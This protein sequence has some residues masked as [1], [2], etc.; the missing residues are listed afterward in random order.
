MRDSVSR[1][2]R[3]RPVGADSQ[4][5]VGGAVEKIVGRRRISQGPV[6]QLLNYLAIHLLLEA[7]YC[8]RRRFLI[9]KVVAI[10]ISEE[11]ARDSDS[12]NN[13]TCRCRFSA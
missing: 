2:I 13:G 12:R 6:R 8:A 5:E 1:T 4:R 7:S 9:T 11:V 3:T 10:C